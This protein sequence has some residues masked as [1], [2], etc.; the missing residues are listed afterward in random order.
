MPQS[1]SPPPGGN[2]PVAVLEDGGPHQSANDHIEITGL[3]NSLDI[4]EEPILKPKDDCSCWW[5]WRKRIVHRHR[6]NARFQLIHEHALH[7]DDLRAISGCP[8]D[9]VTR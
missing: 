7:E 5:V 2:L 6:G 8:V 4:Q 1:K 9:R 3:R